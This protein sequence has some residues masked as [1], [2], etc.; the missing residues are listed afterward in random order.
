M[1]ACVN[2]I[3]QYN[4]HNLKHFGFLFIFL[5]GAGVVAPPP[6]TAPKP[7]AKPTLPRRATS[8]ALPVP[9]AKPIKSSKP[10]PVVAQKPKP[11]Q[12]PVVSPKPPPLESSRPRSVSAGAT[13]SS[14]TAPAVTNGG[15]PP[16]VAFKPKPKPPFKRKSWIASPQQCLDLK[17]NT[18]TTEVISEEKNTPA[19]EE[20]VCDP[21][22][23]TPQ[24]KTEKEERKCVTSESKDHNS[25]SPEESRESLGDTDSNQISQS[26]DDVLR[27]SDPTNLESH[28]PNDELGHCETLKS[29]SIDNTATTPS[30]L[31]IDTPERGE[32]SS[33]VPLPHDNESINNDSSP[34]EDA[35]E[36]AD[37]SITQS[38][39]ASASGSSDVSPVPDTDIVPDSDSPAAVQDSLHNLS[40]SS[41][42]TANSIPTYQPENQSVATDPTSCDDDDA[43][44]E[45]E[46]STKEEPV[47]S[48]KP[49]VPAPRRS[50]SSVTSEVSSLDS[51]DFLSKYN[52]GIVLCKVVYSISCPNG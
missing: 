32:D 33:E 13:P 12:A 46:D 3:F 18:G 42:V 49:P 44:E 28:A 36:T 19:S 22:E 37:T 8:D 41:E 24:D 38:C 47:E 20:S 34:K 14:G 29:N 11:G 15:T 31:P 52:Q 2:I 26:T 40:A 51:Y 25:L 21:T 10:P 35:L 48:P 16:P 50:L 4:S 27:N 30:D 39:E 9:A 6:K 17:E 45:T 23:I 1:G 5:S 7:R 43:F